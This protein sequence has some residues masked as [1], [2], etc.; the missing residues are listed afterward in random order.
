MQK[1]HIV[2]LIVALASAGVS[3]GLWLELR[4][5]RALNADLTAR[6][7][8][9]AATPVTAREPVASRTAEPPVVMAPVVANAAPAPAVAKADR[10]SAD[11]WQAR[12]RKLMSD[13]RY[14]DAFR[15]QQRLQLATR[16]ENFIRL[17]GFSPEQADAVIDLSIERQ[18]NWPSG[19][20]QEQGEQESRTYQE[21]LQALL[22]EDKSA[23][24]QNYMESRQTRMQVD[25]FRTQLTGGDA[26]RD[27]QVEPLIAA[28]QVERSQMQQDLE[29][30]RASFAADDNSE[31]SQRKYN[32]RQTALLKAT[33]DR[34]RTAASAIL[35]QS[36]L[37]KLDAMLKRD[38]ERHEAQQ[39]MARIQSKLE[40]PPELPGNS[41]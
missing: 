7:K 33:H 23:Q 16:R 38:L 10:A 32:E 24:L 4:A 30:Y 5:E 31:A 40:P 28:L 21:K 12:Q 34:M 3:A 39:R 36:Q 35:S 2:L 26:L 6:L 17:L 8:V 29:E 11:F 22:G 27:D 19:I 1:S 14:R 25:Q 37:Q 13:P 20:P 41:N 15:E 9:A 18:M